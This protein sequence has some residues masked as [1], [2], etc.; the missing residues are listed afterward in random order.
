MVDVPYYAGICFEPF[1]SSFLQRAE[2]TMLRFPS[3]LRSI[4]RKVDELTV[5]L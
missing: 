1:L 2:K 4:D 5:S 3:M